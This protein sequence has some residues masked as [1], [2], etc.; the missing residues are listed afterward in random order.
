VKP[1][2]AA[3][4]ALALACA[5]APATPEVPVDRPYHLVDGA[6]AALTD[7][8]FDGRLR[9]ARV[10]YFGERH[11][12]AEDHGAEH[13]LF[14]RVLAA[15]PASGLG[16]EMLPQTY[17]P[18]LDDFTA[19][20][21]DEAAF[22]AAVDWKNTWG[23]AWAFY[24]PLFTAC[25]ERHLRAFALN[26]PRE[27]TRAVSKKGLDG[28]SP[29]EKARLPELVPGPFA[30]REFAREAFGTHAKSRFTDA[31][32]ERFYGV[33][34]VWD[35]SMADAVARALSGTGAPK[36]LFVVAGDGHVRRFAIPDRAARR[37]AAPYLTVV[38]V[39]PDDVKD[40]VAANVADVLWVYATPPRPSP[41]SPGAP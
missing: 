17:Q 41:P 8:G 13:A 4:P 2:R 21:G 20:R 28:L 9:A 39:E 1:L 24:R 26:A 27:N 6:G 15:E 11:T 18:Q 7:A 19:G 10:V 40:A 33:Q 14:A 29:E 22:L 35:E 25:R 5:H 3:L 23:F 34:L 38:G 30:H 37:G 36:K 32:F 12:S 16:V 31:K